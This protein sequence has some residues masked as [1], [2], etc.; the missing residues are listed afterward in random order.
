MNTRRS[1]F[2]RLA[3][4][5][6][7]SFGAFDCFCPLTVSNRR[8][9]IPIIFQKEKRSLL[10]SDLAGQ[11]SLLAVLSGVFVSLYKLLIL[12]LENELFAGKEKSFPL[13]IPAVMIMVFV[14]FRPRF[15]DSYQSDFASL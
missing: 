5:P 1:G 8:P 15:G 14:N 10:V 6:K 9:I 4:V 2:L 3:P 7:S 12:N 13:G 11:L